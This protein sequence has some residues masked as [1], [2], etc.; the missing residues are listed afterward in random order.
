MHKRNET[1]KLHQTTLKSGDVVD[2]FST[3]GRCVARR[4]TVQPSGGSSVY[5][6][7][8][9]GRQYI[10]QRNTGK[11]LLTRCGK[12]SA[13]HEVDAGATT[14][15][16]TVPVAVGDVVRPC[17][18]SVY[19]NCADTTPQVGDLL[20]FSVKGRTVLRVKLTDVLG[21]RTWRAKTA[22]GSRY[23][24]WFTACGTIQAS[25]KNHL[26]RRRTFSTQL[27]MCE[28]ELSCDDPRATGLC[29]Q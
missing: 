29:G 16:R 19:T 26:W 22:N 13:V 27:A 8:A 10:L 15:Q 12:T 6:T 3:K 11:L 18:Q 1:M 21:A 4:L 9:C 14:V 5:L 20:E 2:F 24:V 28:F 25:S 17:P 23:A 7:A